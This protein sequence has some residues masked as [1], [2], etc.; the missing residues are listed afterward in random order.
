MFTNL[1]SQFLMKLSL[2]ADMY[3]KKIQLK[4]QKRRCPYIEITIDLIFTTLTRRLMRNRI[5][6]N[7]T[8]V[9]S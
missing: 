2:Q 7:L 5:F 3:E 1:L 6:Y 4:F 8:C 9:V